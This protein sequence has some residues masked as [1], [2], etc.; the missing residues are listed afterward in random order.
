MTEPASLNDIYRSIGELTGAVKALGDTIESNEKRNVTAIAEANKS[1]A[2]VHKRLDEITAT[3]ADLTTRTSH[4]ESGIASLTSEVGD[5]RKV[6]DDVK[7]MRE[8]ARGAGTLGHWLIKF[9]GWVLGAAATL[10]SVYTWITGRP[11]P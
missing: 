2:N 1:R 6:T 11:P 9:G 10:V 7:V 5:M 8:Q 4:L 3:A